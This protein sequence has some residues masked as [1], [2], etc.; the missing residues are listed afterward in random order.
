MKICSSFQ[1]GPYLSPIFGFDIVAYDDSVMFC[2]EKCTVLDHIDHEVVNEL[3]RSLK[4]MH[5]FHLIHYDINPN[6][7]M[8]SPHFKKPI[9]IDFGFSSSV[10][11]VPGMKTLTIYRGTP[12]FSSKD[13]TRLLGNKQPAG[14]IDVYHNDIHCLQISINRIRELLKEVPNNDS[15]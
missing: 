12:A 7:I 11:E 8:F 5:R 1:C 14:Y 3:K 6:N 9:F 2:M 15:E 13:M 10:A 4:I